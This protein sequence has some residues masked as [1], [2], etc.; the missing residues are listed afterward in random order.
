MFVR[1]K[2]DGK[3]TRWFIVT[4]M[5]AMLLCIKVLALGAVYY[6]FVVR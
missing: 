1:T 6:L 5:A 3:K 2:E 4:D